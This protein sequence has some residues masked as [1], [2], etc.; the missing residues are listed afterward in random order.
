MIVFEYFYDRMDIY[1]PLIDEKA[2][3]QFEKSASN[4]GI[5]DTAIEDIIDDEFDDI[6]SEDEVKEK[7]VF[8]VK[9]I[10]E[11]EVYQSRSQLKSGLGQI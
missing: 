1:A 7:V 3:N 4:Y 10:S 11:L 6:S 9:S 5:E 2:E 8:G